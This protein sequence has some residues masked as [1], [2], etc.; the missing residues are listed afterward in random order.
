[1][2]NGEINA[3]FASCKKSDSRQLYGRMW[4]SG[5]SVYMQRKWR[6]YVAINIYFDR[7]FL[8]FGQFV[9]ASGIGID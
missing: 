2:P 9:S 4:Q 3:I 6:K 8:Y 1:M 7:P 5:S